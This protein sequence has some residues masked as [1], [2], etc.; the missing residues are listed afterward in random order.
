MKPS[1]S[2]AG[3]LLR[4]VARLY[5]RAQ[6]LEAACCDTTSTQCH[7]L[8]ELFRTGTIPMNELGSRLQLEKSWI[9]RAVDTLVERELLAKEPN[10]EDGRSWLVTLT[11]SGKRRAKELNARLNGYAVQ[12]LSRLGAKEQQDVQRALALL[13]NLLRED[14]SATCCLP[15][16]ER[17]K[18]LLCR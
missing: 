2:Q 13:L 9:S 7:I 3:E 14:P 4:E 5:S 1:A 11:A 17:K 18:E 10:P 12:L 15:V 8:T 16:A 6:R